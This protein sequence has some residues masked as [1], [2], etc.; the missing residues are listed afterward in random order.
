MIAPKLYCG[1]ITFDLH[2][3]LQKCSW[4]I[5]QGPGIVTCST[6][7]L[8]MIDLVCVFVEV[9]LTALYF[10]ETYCP[11]LLGLCCIY[12]SALCIWGPLG[13]TW[14]HKA[15]VWVGYSLWS[16]GNNLPCEVYYSEFLDFFFPVWGKHAVNHGW[17]CIG[18][19]VRQM[20]GHRTLLHQSVVGWQCRQSYKM[21]LRYSFIINM[22]YI[23]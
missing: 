16:W 18:E 14:E 22:Q 1:H 21:N 2:P 3:L 8:V 23:S 15:L 7:D 5:K 17:L 19:D 12:A 11:H 20:C 9:F 6:E 13:G 10:R 4:G